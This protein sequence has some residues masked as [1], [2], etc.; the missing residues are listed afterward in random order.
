[1]LISLKWLGRHVELDGVDVDALA[2][3]FTLRVAELEGVT[4]HSADH[5][6]VGGVLSVKDI[7]GTKLH[8]CEVDTGDRRRPIVCGA[9]NVVA[10]RAVV[11]ALPGA[12]VAGNEIVTRPVHGVTS[13]GMICS[14]SELGIAAES[15]GILLLEHGEKPGTPFA[16]VA[17][18][19]DAVFEIDNKSLT[20]RPDLWSHRGIA[21]EVAAMTG[22]PLKPLDLEITFGGDKPFEVHID[23]VERCRR[24]CAVVLRGLKAARSPLWLRVLLHRVGIRP[25]STIVDA[26]N[27]AMLDVGN[28]LHAFD[29]AKISG[30]RIVVRNARAGEP[31]KT[32]DGVERALV[33]TDLVIADESRP[34]ALA[35]VMG[36]WGSRIDETTTEV[37]L[38]AAVFDPG[39]IRGT[40]QR[41][42]LRTEASARYEKDLDVTLPELGLRAFVKLM[43]ELDPNTRVSSALLQAGRLV[44]EPVSVRLRVDRVRRRLGVPELPVETITGYLRALDFK[45]V[46][47]GDGVL[48]VAVPAF[49]AT[50]DIRQ[51]IDLIEEVGRCY[52]YN[53]I[54]PAP[55]TV[56]LSKPHPNRRERAKE[57]VRSYLTQVCG[58]DEVMT[59]SFAYEPFARKLG[60]QPD[61]RRVSVKNPISDEMKSLRTELATNLL[62]ALDRNA[63][64]F[65][66]LGIF[67][68]GRIFLRGPEL[69]V[70]PNLIGALVA[71]AGLREDTQ[72]TLFYRLVGVLKGLGEALDRPAL[73][74]EPGGAP[75]PWA[76]PIRQATVSCA[77]RKLGYVAELHPSTRDKIEERPGAA[78]FE[79]DLDALL[80]IAAV[81][82]AVASVP[83]FPAALRDFAVVVPDGVAA[84]AGEKAIAAASPW[85][86]RVAF[87]SIYR[88]DG[89][90]AGSKSLAYAV[91]LRHPDRTLTEAEV[92]EVATAVWAALAALGGKPR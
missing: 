4:R 90:P 7:P 67:E 13:E 91:T 8:L 15:S 39:T 43:T 42:G 26:T 14:E 53:N 85:I 3:Q 33:A 73:T 56:V 48:E 62:G 79:I 29:R 92:R 37:V 2:N 19:E 68:V 32:L 6:V 77:G 78:L 50:K 38:E 72:A 51:E 81:D 31:L 63:T 34:L 20:H 30:P 10:D 40:S 59:Y 87:Q 22:R 75:L 66:Q 16:R 41:L 12:V 49:R 65:A 1:M 70:Q 57:R 45:V 86:E 82:R 55:S 21:R 76:H 47:A 71:D 54:P 27:F 44:P 36:G 58:L 89:V 28:P 17:P 5:L 35:G 64:T 18:V 11:V 9:A 80:E 24:Y 52:G 84:G 69:P 46:D 23:D 61:E 83:K 88:G 25:L 74:V 60:L